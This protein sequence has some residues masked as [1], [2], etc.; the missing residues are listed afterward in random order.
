MP[1]LVSTFILLTLLVPSAFCS[2]EGTYELIVKK[3]QEEKQ[4]SRWSLAS[5]LSMK[6][7]MSLMDQWLVLNT[8][9]IWFELYLDGAASSSKKDSDLFYAE[10]DMSRYGAGLFFL[11][12]GI[13]YGHYNYSGFKNREWM[14]S[15]RIL[16]SSLQSTNLILSYGTMLRD[17]DTLGELK[18]NFWQARSNLY[19]LDFFGLH[20]GYRQILENQNKARS[21]DLEG[22]K[23]FYGFFLELKLFRFYVEWFEEINE[24]SFIGG[25]FDKLSNKGVYYGLKIYL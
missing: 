1:K 10:D 23:S 2:L 14:G 18:N 16:G 19:L 4:S 22:S 8:D 6:R 3:K 15:L 24:R 9:T 5:W 21:F 13:E 25:G 20:G 12:F 11:P 17:N 7:R